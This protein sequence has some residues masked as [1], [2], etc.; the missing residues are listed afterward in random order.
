M[1]RLVGEMID[2]Q[3]PKGYSKLRQ[4]DEVFID[5]WTAL[6][7]HVRSVA[8]KAVEGMQR[9]PAAG[10]PESKFPF[11]IGQAVQ[12]CR[13]NP[14]WCAALIQNWTWRYLVKYVLESNQGPWPAPISEAFV[15]YYRELLRKSLRERS[16]GDVC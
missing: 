2:L 9:S 6:S 3:T 14:D 11:I 1:Q 8:V 16:F 7:L 10:W 15:T 4:N 5:G 13:V 12:A